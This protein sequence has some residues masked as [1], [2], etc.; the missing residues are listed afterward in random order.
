MGVGRLKREGNRVDEG[1]SSTNSPTTTLMRL[2]EHRV[3]LFIY[4]GWGWC[5]NVFPVV[6]PVVAPL[7]CTLTNSGTG[8]QSHGRLICTVTQI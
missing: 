8:E 3:N 4:S 7:H 5:M 2:T 1:S 6:L